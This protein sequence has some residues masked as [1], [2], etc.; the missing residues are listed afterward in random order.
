MFISRWCR[1]MVATAFLVGLFTL[2]LPVSDLLAQDATGQPTPNPVE[3]QVDRTG[4]LLRQTPDALAAYRDV[5]FVPGELLVGFHNGDTTALQR[6][7]AE[8][9]AAAV[10]QLD[11]RGLDEATGMGAVVG[12]VVRVP[13]G[14]EWATLERLLQDPTVAFVVP[15]WI[16][17][18]ADESAITAVEDEAVATPE[19]PFPIYDPLYA[20]Q[21]W[22]LQ[23][24]NTSHAWSIAY[25]ADGFKGAFAEVQVAIVD[26]GIDVNHPEFRGRLLAG[27][28]YVTS[29]SPPDDDFGHGTHVAGLIG[30]AANNAIG[31]AGVAPK[32]R[33]DPRKVLNSQ[34]TGSITNVSNA[35]REAAD[36]GADIINLSLESPAPNVVM[37]AAVQYAFG[38]GVLL[39]A[40]SGNQ[41]NTTVS[42]PAHYSEV[43]AIAATTYNDTRASYSNSGPEIEIAAPGGERARSMVST[44]PGGVRCR[45]INAAPAQS[46]Y[47]T[48]EGTSMAAAVAS[49]AAAL[50]KSLHPSMSAA[51]IRQLLRDSAYPL[52]QPANFVGRGRLDL[53]AALR[54]ILPPVLQRS[55]TNF[56]R[57]LVPGAPPYTVTLRLDNP[58]HTGLDWQAELIAGNNF[59]DFHHAISD[60]LAGTV[61]YGDPA[62]LS[63][64]ISP[65]NLLTGS[66]AAT[67]RLIERLPDATR[68]THL[69]DLG[70]FVRTSTPVLQYYLPLMLNGTPSAVPAT[71]YYWESPVDPDE[72]MVHRLFDESNI[73]LSLPFTFTLGK[74][75]YVDARLYADGFLRF[76][77]ATTGN[78]LP[79]HCLPNLAEPAQAIYGWWSDLD[80]TVQGARISSFQPAPDRFVVE[81]ANVAS[82]NG[83]TPAYKVSFQIVL[84]RNGDIRLNYRDAPGLTAAAPPVTVGVE[85]RDG[86]FF[87]QVACKDNTVEI[88][89]LPRSQQSLFF[90]AQGAIY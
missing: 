53:H 79:N 24:I 78:N 27:K 14:A 83:I 3:D 16:V 61:A 49:G 64:T 8:V 28:N 20:E 25:G 62:Y 30:A 21:Q 69:I 70:V 73:L 36:A 85:A 5:P 48:S 38:K 76:P 6:M 13:A 57:E 12:Y 41:G 68:R 77:D 2:G 71:G 11:L 55:S 17:Y 75:D 42:W 67:L 46:D 1:R 23:R 66:H 22:Y 58:S 90:D 51:A 19:M 52:N 43:M 35:I 72:R 26:S 29:G 45:D 88:G 60:T 10:E 74:R 89:Y 80:P 34:G 87:N 47:C 65:T 44:W 84:Y 56:V 15:N 40:A 4:T 32:V 37:E 7:A 54:A 63:L 50:I 9:S 39:L 81:F 59:I 86:L 33:I 82:G 31:L 18:A